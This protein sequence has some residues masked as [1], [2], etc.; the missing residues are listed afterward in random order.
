MSLNGKRDGF[1]Q[2]DLLS[3]GTLIG[4]FRQES[5]QI[6]DEIISVV[7]NWQDYANQAGLFDGFATKIAK[8]HRL[9]L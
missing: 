9:S 8:N 2:A 3:V 4:N 6:I 7:E 1:T 5:K